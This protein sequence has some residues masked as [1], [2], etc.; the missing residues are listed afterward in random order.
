M[1]VRKSSLER[2]GGF[3]N[4]LVE[5]FDLCLRAELQGMRIGFCKDA[6]VYDEKVP[7]FRMLIR[8]RSRWFAGHFGL[9][10]EMAMTPKTLTTLMRKNPVDF[11]HML[12]PFYNFCLWV[13]I[14]VGL[15]GFVVN[16]QLVFQN[17]WV[18]S[19]SL[20]MPFLVAQTMLLQGLFVL[21]LKRECGTQEEFKRCTMNLPLFYVFTLLWLLVFWKGLFLRD[22]QNTKTEHGFR[23]K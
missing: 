9:I 2:I 13:G 10:K 8:Q 12:S 14:F 18:L 15:A 16:S 22:W 21:V 3:R 1:A 6:V 23:T 11:L 19:F 20:P 17:T 4:V 7:H 5:D